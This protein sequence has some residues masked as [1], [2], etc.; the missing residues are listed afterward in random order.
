MQ[1][2]T[3]GATSTIPKIHENVTHSYDNTETLNHNSN[4]TIV[5]LLHMV[6]QKTTKKS[7]KGQSPFPINVKLKNRPRP[8]WLSW[9]SRIYF[10]CLLRSIL[11]TIPRGFHITLIFIINTYKYFLARFVI[12]RIFFGELWDAKIFRLKA[13]TKQFV[14]HPA[15]LRRYINHNNDSTDKNKNVL[16]GENCGKTILSL[17]K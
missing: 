4:F 11:A 7:V 8:L 9:N 17:S 15:Q 13:G 2:S 14:I 3:K 12:P 16:V 1:L 10:R 5:L 6:L